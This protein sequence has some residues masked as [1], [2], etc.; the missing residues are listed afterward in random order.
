MLEWLYEVLWIKNKPLTVLM[1]CR[2]KRKSKL[3]A[4]T[5][6][7]HV[8]GDKFLLY[9]NFLSEPKQA[10]RIGIW[11]FLKHRLHS[12]RYRT[13]FILLWYSF[14]SNIRKP[15][16]IISTLTATLLP[17]G[18]LL[19]ISGKGIKYLFFPPF[20]LSLHL[21]CFP[22]NI[23]NGRKSVIFWHFQPLTSCV[24]PDFF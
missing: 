14:P 16:E 7:R 5:A 8:V 15:T 2:V 24:F 4:T 11:E 18:I 19:A 1:L 23:F 21:E 22:T 17:R 20:F 6:T 12:W 3:T 10:P 13:R 9:M